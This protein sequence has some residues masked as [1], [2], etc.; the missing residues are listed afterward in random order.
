MKKFKKLLSA[1]C[2]WG[3]VANMFVFSYAVFEGL[4]GLQVLSLV[5]ISLL[6]VHF[7]VER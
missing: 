7:I 1:L 2:M 6:L 3:I 5:N 4:N